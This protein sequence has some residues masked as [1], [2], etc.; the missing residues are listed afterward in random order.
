MTVVR[1][2]AGFSR[3]TYSTSVMDP[4]RAPVDHILR[5]LVLT[6]SF[7]QAMID[8]NK[9]VLIYHGIELGR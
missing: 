3:L 1:L 9:G 5:P 4:G 6:V 7:V 8:S 2:R